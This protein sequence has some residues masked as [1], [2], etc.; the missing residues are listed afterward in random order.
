MPTTIALSGFK[1]FEAKCKNL[2]KII[3]EEM[4]GEVEES[5]RHW[6]SLAKRDAPKDQGFLAGQITNKKIK[7]AEWETVSPAEYS[8]YLEWGTKTKVQIPAELQAYANQFRTKGTG[9]AKKMIYAWMKRVGIPVQFQ[10]PVFFSII[11]KGVNPHPFFF[12]QKPIVEKEFITRAQKIL[13][14][15][16]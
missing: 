12:I 16:H 9:D 10:W 2:P 5:S 6:A 15:E 7:L 11:T 1:E 4:D 13:N 3:M 8:A 14:T